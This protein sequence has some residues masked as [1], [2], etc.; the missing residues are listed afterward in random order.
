MIVSGLTGLPARRKI[1][2]H[3]NNT[4]PVLLP[5]S[6]ERAAVERAGIEV[7]GDGWEFDL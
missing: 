5:E 2:L 6:P 4:N 7:G 3:V 1:Y